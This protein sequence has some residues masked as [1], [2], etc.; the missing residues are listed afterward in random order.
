[1]LDSPFW[2]WLTVGAVA[3]GM[4]AALVFVIRF[5]AEV[6]WSWWRSPFGRFLMIRK[7]LLTGLFSVVLLNRLIGDWPGRSALTALLM[8]AFAIQTFV[9]YQLLMRVQRE[10]QERADADHE[11]Q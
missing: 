6:G 4:L 2:G 7:T 11:R 3:L 5:Q 9:P 1:M 8:L 10:Q